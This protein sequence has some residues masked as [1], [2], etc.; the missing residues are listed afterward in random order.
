MMML[1][2][3]ACV[4]SRELLREHSQRTEILSGWKDIAK[5]LG[6]GVRTVQRY[7]R[8]LNLPIRRPHGGVSGSVIAIKAELDAWVTARPIGEDLQLLG[9]GVDN[10]EVL[11]EFRQSMREFSRLQRESMELRKEHRRAVEVLR[12]NLLQ[13]A[14]ARLENGAC[15]AMPHEGSTGDRRI[16]ARSFPFQTGTKAA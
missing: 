9:A 1:A 8:E 14:I 3:K 4:V 10:T 6:R 2:P 15:A 16:A 5:Y 13:Y 12:K 7:E 11:D